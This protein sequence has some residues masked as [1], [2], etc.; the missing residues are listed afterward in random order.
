MLSRS[1]QVARLRSSSRFIPRSAA[2]SRSSEESGARRR[3]PLPAV[4]RVI[5]CL[6]ASSRE[7]AREISPT[8]ASLPTILETVLWCVNVRSARSF[9]DHSFPPSRARRTSSCAA[10]T[11][12]FSSTGL[13]VA[14]S[15]CA[16]DRMESTMTD[17]SGADR[18]VGLL[19]PEGLTLIAIN[20]V[21]TVGRLHASSGHY[22]HQS[23]KVPQRL[24][25]ARQRD[26]APPAEIPAK[27]VRCGAGS[28]Y[29]E[30]AAFTAIDDA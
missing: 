4:V 25:T 2:S 26:V 29:L 5:A 10:V 15:S 14:R 18:T 23:Y 3:T 12:S 30:R 24:R 9:T 17:F 21:S 28:K 13:P 19:V 22:P 16:I 27:K 6:R 20:S 11:P 8:S 7:D 1:R